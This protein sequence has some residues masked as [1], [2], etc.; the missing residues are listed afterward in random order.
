M[1]PTDYYRLKSAEIDEDDVR[2]VAKIMSD[3]IGEKNTIELDTLS[4]LTGIRDRQLRNILEELVTKYN[5]LIGAHSGASGRW[6]IATE[7]ERWHVANELMRREDSLRKRRHI[8]ERTALPSETELKM[9][10]QAGLF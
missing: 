4:E 10:E 6:I 9:S 5:I 8:I 3:H 2:L 1:N 7:E